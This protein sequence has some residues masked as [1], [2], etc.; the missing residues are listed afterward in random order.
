MGTRMICSGSSM[1]P[2]LKPGDLI[3]IASADPVRPG[4]VIVFLPPATEDR[5]VHRVIRVDGFGI[6]TRGDNSLEADPWVLREQNI[7][8][9][10]ARVHGS[11]GTPRCVVGGRLGLV[12]GTALRSVHGVK[13]KLTSW[14]RPLYHLLSRW[15][16]PGRFLHPV[17]CPWILSTAAG[18]GCELQLFIGKRMIGRLRSGGPWEIRPPYRLCV[19][20]SRLPRVSMSSVHPRATE[21]R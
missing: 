9:Q 8:G 17:L 13:R 21:K 11:A 19:D 7:L 15:G 16:F 20:V 5:V 6:R 4:D 12:Y 10:V 2:T 18:K 14:L 1:K 3:E